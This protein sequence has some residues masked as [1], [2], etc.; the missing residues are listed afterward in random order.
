MSRREGGM[1]RSGQYYL[2]FA[3][4]Q[5]MLSFEDLNAIEELHR[6]GKVDFSQ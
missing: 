2:A 6:V 3:A 4:V 1:L 5:H